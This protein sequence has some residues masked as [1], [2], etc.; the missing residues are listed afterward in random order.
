MSP[1]PSQFI[2]DA[3]TDQLFAGN[4]AAVC[5]QPL[6]EALMQRVAQENNLSETAFLTKTGDGYALR[7]FTPAGEIDLC[8]HATLAAAHVVLTQ[9]EPGRQQVTFH[10]CSGP[11]PVQK[12][13]DRYEMDFPAYT[14]S[15]VPVTEAMAAAFGA[16]PTAAYLGR[17]LLCVFDREETVG[18]LTPGRHPLRHP[19]GGPGE[20]VWKGRDLRRHHVFP[21]WRFPYGPVPEALNS[22]CAPVEWTGGGVFLPGSRVAIP[23]IVSYNTGSNS[24]RKDNRHA[25]R[26]FL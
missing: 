11:L 9:L 20:A 1:F 12:R 21:P 14:L 17:D 3:F 25:Q 24:A 22:L 13:G 2:V 18:G 8:G 26:H 10:T 15:P 4:P 19:G 5:L 23:G 7:W 6:P 16:R